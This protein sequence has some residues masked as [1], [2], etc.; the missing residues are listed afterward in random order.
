MCHLSINEFANESLLYWKYLIIAIKWSFLLKSFPKVSQ[1]NNI[2]KYKYI[3]FVILLLLLLLWF[4]TYSS[5][6]C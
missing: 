2:Y 3:K 5:L 6:F 4:S 1:L